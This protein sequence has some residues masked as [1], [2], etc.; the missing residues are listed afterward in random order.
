MSLEDDRA[1]MRRAIELGRRGLGRTSP[2]PPVGAV[3]VR[4]GRVV[5]EGWHRRAGGPHAEVFALREAGRRARGATLYCTLEPC[6]HHGRT[7]P[8]APLV[9]EAGIARIVVG[10]VDPNPRVRGR[11]LRLLRSAGI[12]V[13]VGVE[14]DA[15]RRLIRFFAHRLRQGRPFVRLKIASSADGRVATRTGASRWITGAPAR[16]L[17]QRWRDEFDAVAVG[18]DTV[19]ADDPRLTCRRRGGR[20]PLRVVFDSRLR[21]PEGARL[22]REGDSPAWIVTLE[23]YDAR[24]AARLERR[25]ARVLAV[26]GRGPRLDLRRALEALAAEGIASVLV[27]GGPR[28]SGGLLRAGVV[29]ELCWFTAPLLVGGDGMPMVAGLGVRGLGEALRLVPLG[30][31]R[32]GADLLQVARPVGPGRSRSLKVRA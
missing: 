22:L 17:V 4:D 9:L 2:N 7:P 27:E 25:G 12:E 1:A 28:L 31:A 8:C 26:A 11:G 30:A 18:V 16:A 14:G 6:S 23:G 19:I 13:D 21:T 5:G 24:K 15:A 29:D 10:A 20:D 3:V 32:V